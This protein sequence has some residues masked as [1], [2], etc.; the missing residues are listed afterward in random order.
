M[1]LLTLST[2]ICISIRSVYEKYKQNDT[3]LLLVNSDFTALR[4]ISLV[5]KIPV[6]L[7]QKVINIRKSGHQTLIYFII[8]QVIIS[9]RQMI[10]SIDCS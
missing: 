5:F 8:I 6:F 10:A 3:A 1:V 2:E 4:A 7:F 9:L